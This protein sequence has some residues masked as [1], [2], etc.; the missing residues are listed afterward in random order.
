VYTGP[1]Q[2]RCRLDV[3]NTMLLRSNGGCDGFCR[4]LL[5]AEAGRSDLQRAGPSIS[6]FH[7]FGVPGPSTVCAGSAANRCDAFLH[8][9]F[10]SAARP[11]VLGCRFVWA[12]DMWVSVS[13]SLKSRHGFAVRVVIYA[14]S[15]LESRPMPTWKW[16][17]GAISPRTPYRRRTRLAQHNEHSVRA[18]EWSIGQNARY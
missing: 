16:A 10:S 14:A 9:Y 15:F 5:L 4:D 7:N 18:R 11:T 6:T 12:V 17:S 1:L 3:R 8:S 2:R 13:V